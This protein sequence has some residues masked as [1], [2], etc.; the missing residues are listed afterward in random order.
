VFV[1]SEKTIRDLRGFCLGP[2]PRDLHVQ[3]VGVDLDLFRP[4][5]PGEAKDRLGYSGRFVVLHV[6]RLTVNKGADELIRA[7]PAVAD[8]IPD[9]VFV[10]V[11]SGPAASDLKRAAAR[12]GVERYVEFVGSVPNRELPQF[13]NAADVFINPTRE[14][15][16]FG[17]TT[18]EAMACGTPVII[19]RCGAETGIVTPGEGKIYD[20]TEELIA[21]VKRVQGETGQR[22]DLAVMR[23]QRAERFSSAHVSARLEESYQ[24]L[25]SAGK[26][27]AAARS[28]RQW[29]RF[30]CAALA[31][32]LIRWSRRV[33]RRM[34]PGGTGPTR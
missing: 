21:A 14:N 34:P 22:G 9:V 4:A 29:G 24:D 28:A 20:G 13:Y 3:P 2:E 1:P 32:G 31:D 18:V 26:T 15:E 25:V 19:S 16:T 17:L 12:L 11:G 10:I 33:R 5:D 6:G 7:A 30:W 8:P 27:D 23:R